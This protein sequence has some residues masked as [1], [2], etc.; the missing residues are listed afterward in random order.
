MEQGNK[1]KTGEN[2]QEEEPGEICTVPMIMRKRVFGECWGFLTGS[3]QATRNIP[4]TLAWSPS[5]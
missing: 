1:S 4:Q 2:H 5:T 3:I